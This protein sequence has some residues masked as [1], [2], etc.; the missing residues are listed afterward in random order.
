MTHRSLALLFLCTFSFSVLF[1]VPI[2]SRGATEETVSALRDKIADQNSE[3]ADIQKEIKLY[4]QKLKEAG[5]ERQTLESALR[6][7]EASRGKLTA[8]IKLTTRK[9]GEADQKIGS[10]ETDISRLTERIVGNREATRGALQQ[11][12]ESE[13]QTFVEII[14]SNDSFGDL[15]SDMDALALFQDSLGEHL[16]ALAKNREALAQA[17]DS[18]RRERGELSRLASDLSGENNAL[19]AT[20]TEKK[21]LLS[22]TKNKEANYQTLLKE[23]QAARTRMENDLR[24][25]EATLRIIVDTNKFPTQGSRV[26]SSPVPGAPI[27]QGYGL[28]DFARGGAYGYNSAGQPNPHRGIDYGV[29]I[30]T[31]VRAA[32]S[33]IVRGAENM[34]AYAGCYSFGKWILVEH[35]NGLST[36]YAHLSSFAVNVGENVA[37]GQII[38]ASG[39]SGYSTNPH[40]HFGLYATE[41]IRIQ[42]YTSSNGC[43]NALVPLASPDAYLNPASYF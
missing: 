7:L 18:V 17:K 10:I 33:G 43:K 42:K 23:K 32:L 3:L 25:L 35:P 38:G 8:E 27:T 31:P 11:L 1:A 22:V 2:I 20:A 19:V 4:E 41:G 26:L 13:Q 34:D 6:A 21:N 39:N 15:W 36:L 37:T 40:L 12:D 28:T 14:L 24:A 30:G 29:G 9:M 16:T 5:G